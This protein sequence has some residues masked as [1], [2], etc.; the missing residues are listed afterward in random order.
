MAPFYNRAPWNL[1]IGVGYV[2]VLLYGVAVA[3]SPWVVAGIFG[4]IAISLLR[5]R[6]IRWSDLRHKS[7]FGGR[8]VRDTWVYEERE[9]PDRRALV[10]EMRNTEPG[11][12]KL[13]LPSQSEWRTSVPAWAQDRQE[14]IVRRIAERLDSADIH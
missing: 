13:F 3:T 4:L 1:V 12:F 10:L 6:F 5:Q 8:R 9:G 7:Y 14:E 2:A 11:H